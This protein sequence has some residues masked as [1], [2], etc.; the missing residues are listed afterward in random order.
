[1]N[2]AP[3]EVRQAVANLQNG[4]GTQADKDVIYHYLTSTAVDRQSVDYLQT[5][6]ATPTAAPTVPGLQP[7]GTSS[8]SP[9]MGG[10][11]GTDWVVEA[12]NQGL[13]TEPSPP[14]PGFD[15][16]SPFDFFGDLGS[17]AHTTLENAGAFPPSSPTLA[18][19]S[20]QFVGMGNGGALT[21]PGAQP[22]TPPPPMGPPLV[23]G[24][25][26]WK[27]YDPTNIGA[28]RDTTGVI[29]ASG[30]P[31]DAGAERARQQAIRRAG[32]G[33][34]PAGGGENWKQAVQ[35]F[36]LDPSSPFA[37]M[38]PEA[39]NLYANDPSALANLLYGS[40]GG[41]A[42]FMTPQVNAALQLS[43]LGVLGRHGK[44]GIGTGPGSETGN[45]V[46]AEQFVNA[47]GQGQFI[48]PE[49]VQRRALRAL[50]NTPEEMFATGSGGASDWRSQVEVS[51][52]ALLDTAGAYM[53]EDS[54]RALSVRIDM[55]AQQWLQA[56]ARGE[57]VGTFPQFL[58]DQGAAHW[59]R[60]GV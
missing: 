19:R 3:P 26:D 56:M 50:R 33:G 7:G 47:P 2:N 48:D 41:A 10:G 49:W 17:S 34:D 54:A 6:L 37:G 53:G 44:G 25:E 16:G 15:G 11:P 5:L 31:Q 29:S 14:S 12:Q 36:G 59:V 43:R 42:D 35:E 58:K 13:T 30:S 45:V 40:G 1:M 28:P 22:D 18:G 21:P 23:G 9:A 27:Q 4:T 46:Q 39:A 8:A 38:N 57:Q 20:P 32:R 60:S 55:A 24:Q 52:N 51:R